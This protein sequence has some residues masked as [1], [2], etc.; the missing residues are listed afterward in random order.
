MMT[1]NLPAELGSLGLLDDSVGLKR[2]SCCYGGT[3]SESFRHATKEPTYFHLQIFTGHLNKDGGG[4]ER[5]LRS[6]NFSFAWP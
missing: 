5:A 3:P 4:V 6:I 2:C 1:P